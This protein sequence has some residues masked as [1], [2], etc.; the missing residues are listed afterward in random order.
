V[1]LYLAAGESVAYR[2]R[3]I[4]HPSFTVYIL[5]AVHQIVLEVLRLLPLQFHLVGQHGAEVVGHVLLAL[6]VG[7]VGFDA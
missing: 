2:I 6:V 4:G 7:D 1:P 3:R 5:V